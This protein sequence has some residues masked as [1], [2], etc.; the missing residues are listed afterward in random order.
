MDTKEAGDPL[1]G[2]VKGPREGSESSHLEVW[3]RSPRPKE[4]W[5]S[6]GGKCEGGGE[7]GEGPW[8]VWP[9]SWRGLD[10]AFTCET[11]E[12]GDGAPDVSDASTL[13]SYSGQGPQPP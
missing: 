5:G 4:G 1:G 7:G 3:G 11:A 13:A 2:E 8:A 9:F 12:R 6:G 10:A